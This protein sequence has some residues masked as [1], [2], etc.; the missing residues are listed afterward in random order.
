[1]LS[2]F[3]CFFCA[4]VLLFL[5]IRASA[6]QKQDLPHAKTLEDLQKAME[7]LL[8]K[9]HVPGAGIALIVNGEV[10]WCGGIGKADIATNHS[11]GCDT[12]FR[13]GSISKTFVA[14]ALLK[15]QEEGK[16]NLY[17]RLQDVAPE[18]PVK[19]RWEATNPVRIVNLLEH[20]AGFD[21]ME[22]SEVYNLRDRYDYPLLAVFQRFQKPQEVRWPPGTRMSYSNP[23]YGVAGYLIEK[24][25]RRP[26]DTYIRETF[27]R[28]LGMENADF[29]FTDANKPLLA[30]GY[31]GNPPRA[32]GYPFIYLR[33]AGDLKTSP[34]EMAKLVQFLLRRG[35]AGDAHL[36]KPESIL[37]METPETTLA[38]QHGL[39]LG[40]GL[41]NY[42]QVEGGVVTHGHNGGIDGFLSTYRYMPEQNWGYVILL[43]SAN[44]GT[45]LREMNRLAIDFLS[46]D[47]PKT[48]QPT[49]PMAA[50]DLEKFTGYYA[51]RAPRNQLFAFLEDLTGGVRI[52][53]INGQLTLSG[54]FGQPEPLLPVAFNLFREEKEPEGA[55]LF[56]HDPNGS[57]ALTSNGLEGIAYAERSSLLVVYAKIA[58][59]ILCLVLM[60]TSLLFVPVWGLR[61]LFGG[62]KGVRHLWVRA[63]PVLGILALLTVPYCFTR[64]NGPQVGTFN[65]WTVGIF[66]GT[67]LFP[68]LSLAALLL[69]L[70]VPKTEIHRGVRLHSLLVSSA[71]CILTSFLLSWHLV[72]LRLWTP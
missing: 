36:L 47:S 60:A 61:K 20:T 53:V 33:P 34:G 18:V 58:L 49:I 56:F 23:G 38:A 6:Q 45:A 69:A 29:T 54:I 67:L 8:D 37:R 44:S 26:F 25:A 1:M 21:D 15:L 68:V 27:L 39:R 72:A 32:V 19:N 24:A 14:L 63:A 28:P 64:L 62:M 11:V 40:Y 2:K 51:P 12:E 17:A 70:R 10:S 65:V 57:M 3:I 52:R 7:A 46:K 4:V 55:T 50:G 31:D 59:L 22:L 66:L 16:I 42:T 35:R 5:P 13:V 71:C 41:A 9:E 30:T 48:Q 43:N